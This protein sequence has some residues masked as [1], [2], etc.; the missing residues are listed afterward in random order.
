[1]STP[2]RTTSRRAP[3]SPFTSP[4][5]D[6]GFGDNDDQAERMAARRAKAA[7]NAA[8]P[9]KS[10]GAAPSRSNSRVPPQRSNSRAPPGGG[11]HGGK[12][13]DDAMMDIYNNCIKLSADNV[14]P[15]P[16]ARRSSLVCVQLRWPVQATSAQLPKP[17]ASECD[18]AAP[19]PSTEN[20]YEEHME[21]VHD[22]SHAGHGGLVHGAGCG[23]QHELPDGQW[24]GRGWCKNLL[25]ACR[26]CRHRGLQGAQQ[27]V[28]RKQQRWCVC[29]F[30][31]PR[32]SPHWGIT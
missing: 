13:S 19:L 20:Q 1:M 12:L 26:L 25:V 27:P 10:P 2:R 21:P 30:C 9:Y 24:R 32:D 3:K 7:K 4:G 15:P 31:V 17:H 22:R 14:R 18:A 11:K 23:R 6:E 5:A 28:A 29:L 8:S 16:R